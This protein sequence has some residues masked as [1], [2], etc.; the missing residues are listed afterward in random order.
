MYG[1]GNPNTL[2]FTL[3]KGRLVFDPGLAEK[4]RSVNSLE[5]ISDATG[6][7]DGNIVVDREMARYESRGRN[8]EYQFPCGCRFRW[9]G[10]DIKWQ[11]LETGKLCQIFNR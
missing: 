10:R 11:T 4:Q 3:R 5:R 2:G 6:G 1:E 8:G 9:S 7:H